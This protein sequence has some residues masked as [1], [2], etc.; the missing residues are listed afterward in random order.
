MQVN[1]PKTISSVFSRN[2]A[3]QKGMAQCIKSDEREKPI[4]KN[5]LPSKTF[6]Q[7]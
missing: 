3:G 4:I 2:S 1:S 5:N 6:I 7:I